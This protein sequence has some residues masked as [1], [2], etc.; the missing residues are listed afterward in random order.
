[1]AQFG[2]NFNR[3]ARFYGFDFSYGGFEAV[4][5]ENGLWTKKN[6][7]GTAYLPDTAIGDS[8]PTLVF[9]EDGRGVSEVSFRYESSGLV[10]SD[11]RR[12]MEITV[13]SFA[14]ARKGFGLFSKGRKELLSAIET[15]PFESFEYSHGGITVRCAVDYSGYFLIGGR[16]LVSDDRAGEERSCTVA[17]SVGRTE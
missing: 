15:H 3:L 16:A 11:C 1:M 9:R 13:L 8:V 4:L 10:P 6:G 5:D 2:D 17:F 12:E 14:C 7:E